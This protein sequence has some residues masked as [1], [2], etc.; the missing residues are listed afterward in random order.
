MLQGFLACVQQGS[1]SSCESAS[2]CMTGFVARQARVV[3]G[4]ST[5][6]ATSSNTACWCCV[7]LGAGSGG[8]DEPY[9]LPEHLREAVERQYRR[10]VE[11][12][13][14]EEAGKLDDEYKSFIQVHT[15]LLCWGFLSW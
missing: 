9:R 2:I 4:T 13:H 5:I 7:S 14:G 6:A 3:A 8:A 11:R 10:D 1:T 15:D 12:V